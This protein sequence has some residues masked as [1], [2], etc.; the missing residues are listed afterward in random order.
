EVRC[1]GLGF[2][3]VAIAAASAGCGMY[4]KR[5]PATPTSDRAQ[6]F[7][8]AR[9][10]PLPLAAMAADGPGGTPMVD[11]AGAVA[12]PGTLQIEPALETVRQVIE[13]AGGIVSQGRVLRIRAGDDAAAKL[14]AHDAK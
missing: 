10:E 9:A 2:V 12:R 1:A 11:V 14:F 13:A 4:V 6:A 5:A 7:F 8:Q 3:A